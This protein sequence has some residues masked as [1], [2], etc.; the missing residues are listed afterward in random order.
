MALGWNC[1]YYLHTDVFINQGY[2]NSRHKNFHLHVLIT[3]YI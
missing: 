2:A 1:F 3:A